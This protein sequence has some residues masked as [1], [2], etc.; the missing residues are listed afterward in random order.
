MLISEVF[1][2]TIQGEG[3]AAG[4]SAA[5]V[6]LGGCNLDCSWCDTP[7]TWDW[8]GKNGYAYDR[9][10]ELTEVDVDVVLE[11]VAAMN[12]QIV[13]VSGGEPL[14]PV[15]NVAMT[16]FS[17]HWEGLDKSHLWIETNGTYSPRGWTKGWSVVV[18]P[19]LPSSGVSRD[20]VNLDALIAWQNEEA[21]FKFVIGDEL[22][23]VE[24]DRLISA[25]N[26]PRSRV[27]FMPEARTKEELDNRAGAAVAAAL[28]SEVQYTDRLHIRLW[29][30]KR[31]V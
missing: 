14:M 16:D 25:A 8:T 12:A 5:F 19:K 3:P 7:Y 17:D 4:K 6:R 21:F 13:V 23:R 26:I 29:G 18:S 9:S 2:P 28:K 27:Y 20:K 10:A 22:D 11:V 24:A 1:G 31:G 30:D 15:H